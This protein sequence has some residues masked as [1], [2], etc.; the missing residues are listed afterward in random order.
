[1]LVLALALVLALSLPLASSEEASERIDDILTAAMCYGLGRGR[2]RTVYGAKVIYK[3][4]GKKKKVA[5]AR[6][7]RYRGRVGA[8]MVASV[9]GAISRAQPQS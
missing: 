3:L 4:G 8:L 5:C 2:I 1:M 9:S 6:L 7:L